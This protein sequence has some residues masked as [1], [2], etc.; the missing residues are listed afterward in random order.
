[1]TKQ[2]DNADSIATYQSATVGTTV[3]TCDY[4]LIL[5]KY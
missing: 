2:E 4:R 1:M 5:E 3:S